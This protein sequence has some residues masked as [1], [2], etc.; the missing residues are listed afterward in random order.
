VSPRQSGRKSK[1]RKK[2]QMLTTVATLL[3]L[4]LADALKPSMRPA[5]RTTMASSSPLLYSVATAASRTLL[6][7]CMTVAPGAGTAG[8]ETDLV[9]DGGVMKSVVRAGVGTPPPRGA[10][11]EVHYEGKLLETGAVFDSSRTRG[12]PFRFTLGEG[13][14]I[15]GW[16]V[17]LSS[18]QPGEVCVLTCSPQ[19]AYG[20]KGIP[21]VIPPSATLRF[22][23]ELI[24]VEQSRSEARTFADDNPE[25]PRT[26]ETIKSVRAGA[27]PL[28]RPPPTL[29]PA[30]AASVAA[31]L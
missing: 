3:S 29:D 1:S 27:S 24:S 16:E 19:Y 30:S 22:E 6:A 9:G 20:A 18:M 17:G 28:T 26:P 15:G 31:V 2:N 10:T 4:G 14:V 8:P 25:A 13:K 23:V 5:V 21:P 12:K 7:P 11:V